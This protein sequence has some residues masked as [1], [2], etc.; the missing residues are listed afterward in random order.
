MSARDCATAIE[1]ACASHR[2]AQI[3]RVFNTCMD[4]FLK[5]GKF[6]WPLISL[7]SMSNVFANMRFHEHSAAHRCSSMH[8]Y[9]TPVKRLDS[10]L[11]GVQ[12]YTYMCICAMKRAIR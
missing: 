9:E 2:T 4:F 8:V 1:C 12:I 6:Y 5:K 7:A 10:M 11:D 3:A